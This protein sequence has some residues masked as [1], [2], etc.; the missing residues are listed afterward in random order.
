M[1]STTSAFCIGVL[2]SEL[3][4]FWSPT[5]ISCINLWVCTLLP[6][7]KQTLVKVTFHPTDV[8][9]FS[10][11][12]LLH[13]CFFLLIYAVLLP[14]NQSSLPLSSPAVLTFSDVQI[15]TAQ[16]GLNTYASWPNDF[17]FFLG[18]SLSLRISFKSPTATST[19]CILLTVTLQLHNF[20]KTKIFQIDK[21]FNTV[22]FAATFSSICAVVFLSVAEDHFLFCVHIH[23]AL[24]CSLVPYSTLT[25]L[26]KLLFSCLSSFWHSTITY[27]HL[28]NNRLSKCLNNT[29]DFAWRQKQESDTTVTVKFS[30]KQLWKR[31]ASTVLPMQT[32][33]L[34][35]QPE[36]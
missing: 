24:D 34:P 4:C 21:T 35:Q 31:V 18:N 5:A 9:I 22:H 11:E 2:P 27:F 1:N 29:E 19:S 12:S 32:Y 14:N 28:V 6:G 36:Q 30:S 25:S 10:E 16:G 23:I 8:S 20:T 33:L 3:Q 7:Q 13:F 17:F 15:T 26:C